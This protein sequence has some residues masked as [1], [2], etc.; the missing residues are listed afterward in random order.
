MTPDLSSAISVLL[1][2]DDDRFR[3]RMAKA[4]Q[5]RGYDVRQAVDAESWLLLAQQDSPEWAVVDLRMPGDSGL[6]LIRDLRLLDPATRVVLLTGYGSMATAVDAMRLGA[7][8]VLAKP[9]DADTLL[10]AFTRVHDPVLAPSA[11][12]EPQTLAQ[13]EWEH[14]QR[15]LSDCGQNISEAARRLG[16][17]RR[18]LQRKLFKFAP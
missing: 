11:E 2:D 3:E 18:S 16:L 10:A 9:V 6:T 14:I 13:V 12:Y 8:H 15:V 5:K 1:V 7:H 4:L 17:H